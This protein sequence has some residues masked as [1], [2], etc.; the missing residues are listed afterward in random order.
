MDFSRERLGI[1]PSLGVST[2]LTAL[3]AAAPTRNASTPCTLD[4][5]ARLA[6]VIRGAEQL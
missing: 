5:A 6:Q 3:K 4:A 2:Q 1:E